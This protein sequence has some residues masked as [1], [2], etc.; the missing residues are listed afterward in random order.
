[1]YKFSIKFTMLLALALMWAGMASASHFRGAALMPSV[2]ASGLLTVTSTSFWR[3]GAADTIIP[4]STQG[5]MVVGSNVLDASDIRFDKR[6]AVFTQ[7]LRG[8]GLHTISMGSCCRVSGIAN[9]GSASWTMNSAIRWDGSTANAPILF[10]FSSIQSEVVRTAPLYSDNLGA[11]A[12]AGL[13]LSY[14]SNTN[15]FSGQPPGYSVNAAT[16]QITIS[17][18]SLLTNENI[19]NLGADYAFSGNILASD[20]SFVQ[21]DWLFDAVNQGTN[22]APNVNDAVIYALAGDV[23]T[24]TVTATDPNNDPLTWDMVNFFG[25]AG[26]LS[27]T[28]DP[29]T[30]LLSWD[31]TGLS[32]GDVLQALIRA[33]D[34]SL[35]DVGIMIINIGCPPND[36][37]CGTTT[38][39][40]VPEPGTLLLLSIGLL[41]FGA[42]RRGRKK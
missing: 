8:A 25:P 16:G 24:Y 28:F 37:T 13:T 32:N 41:G 22:L 4:S 17:D 26:A 23:V 19:S 18:P 29:L 14:N 21:F 20:G 39:P 11:I 40:S 5:F 33:S 34:G 7:Q 30:Q 36:P 15:G 42:S 35:T 27:P 1:M 9:V 3:K 38:P 6:T 10:D 12:G 2:S 31:T